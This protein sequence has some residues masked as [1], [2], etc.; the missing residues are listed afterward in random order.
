MSVLTMKMT[1]TKPLISSAA[2]L[3][4]QLEEEDLTLRFKALEKLHGI[5]D[6]FWAEI[7]EAVPLI[8]ALSEDE[9]FPHRQLAASVAS[10]CFFSS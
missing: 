4:S 6:Y 7:S 2:G 5:V 10:K 3:L 1:Q 8:E 9:T